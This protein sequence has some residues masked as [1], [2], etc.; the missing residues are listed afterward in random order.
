MLC[1]LCLDL[2]AVQMITVKKH[3]EIG[4][5]PFR[6][7]IWSGENDPGRVFQTLPVMQG[8][9]PALCNFLVDMPEINDPHDSFKFIHTGIGTD[10]INVLRRRKTEIDQLVQ[11]LKQGT[12]SCGIS[13]NSP[14]YGMKDLGG[15]SGK[16]GKVSEIAN[17][18]SFIPYPECVRCIVEQKQMVTL[19]DVC[20]TF[21]ITWKPVDMSG[22][23]GNRFVC[24]GALNQIRVNGEGPGLHIHKYRSQ[25]IA[26]N[27]MGGGTVGI[28]G[29]ND[30]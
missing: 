5:V 1:K 16:H 8:S 14:L 15:M 29:G 2:I 20:Q 3:G 9:S 10:V 24:D 23:D 17:A 6:I 25:S 26:D 30:L 7:G 11:G 18:D 19:C 13:D 12:V 28:R 4:I 27:G 22:N 21:Q